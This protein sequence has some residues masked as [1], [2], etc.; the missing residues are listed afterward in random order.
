MPSQET[1][2]RHIVESR[3][4]DRI[5]RW[6]PAGSMMLVSV[7]GSSTGTRWRCWR[8]PFST[9]LKDTHLSVTEYGWV[10]SAYSILF[11][12]GNPLWGKILDR[13]ELRRGMSAARFAV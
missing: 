8:Q 7:I 3:T 2:V 6:A 10:V 4:A 13:L 12:I 1:V 5:T 9:Q 11:T